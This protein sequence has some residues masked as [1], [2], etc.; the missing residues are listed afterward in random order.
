MA[1]ILKKAAITLATALTTAAASAQGFS[2]WVGPSHHDRPHHDRSY[3]DR[4]YNDRHYSGPRYDNP[5]HPQHPRHY[6][7]LETA[8][9]KCNRAIFNQ[10]RLNVH[11]PRT[12]VGFIE[13]HRFA[14]RINLK[15]GRLTNAYNLDSRSGENAFENAKDT[16]YDREYPRHYRNHPQW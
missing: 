10:A 7:P 5:R 12:Q 3:N 1:G 9:D 16:A 2:I 15:T 14:C 13:G 4:S 6:A 11:H 8:T